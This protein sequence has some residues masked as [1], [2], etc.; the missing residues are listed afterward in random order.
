MQLLSGDVS[1]LDII[2]N[3]RLWTYFTN[4]I[5]MIMGF[6]PFSVFPYNLTELSLENY[7]TVFRFNLISA[8]TLDFIQF[9]SF[10]CNE[11]SG[12]CCIIGETA[13]R[14]LMI[15]HFQLKIPYL[16]CCCVTEPLIK[17]IWRGMIIILSTNRFNHN[18]SKWI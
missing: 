18:R 1:W 12:Y 15:F 2:W 7:S 11:T 9:K 10:S 13:W 8:N 17:N 6:M 4:I 5:L 14:S 16:C 3:M